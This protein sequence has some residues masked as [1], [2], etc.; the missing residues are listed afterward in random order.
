MLIKKITKIA[1][2]PKKIKPLNIIEKNTRNTV[3][4]QNNNI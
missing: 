1:K 2:K 4:E 3:E